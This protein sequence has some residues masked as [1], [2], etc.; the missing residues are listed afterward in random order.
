MKV[1][2]SD[3]PLD[4]NQLVLLMDFFSVYCLLGRTICFSTSLGDKL[5]FQ[6]WHFQLLNWIAYKTN[7]NERKRSERFN[8]SLITR[9]LDDFVTEMEEGINQ[10]ALTWLFSRCRGGGD[11]WL[12]S[13]CIE[14]I[15][16]LGS[17]ESNNRWL[18][19]DLRVILP[20][21]LRSI[22]KRAEIKI[23]LK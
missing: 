18:G 13:R 14:M 10:F 22:R 12:C 17:R 3:S 8:L 2:K 21:S 4:F 23:W 6:F 11:P 16:G 9:F 20:S 5:C 19:I 1:K 7:E 15:L